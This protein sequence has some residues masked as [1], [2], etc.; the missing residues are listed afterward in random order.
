MKGYLTKIT[1]IFTTAASLQ[2]CAFLFDFSHLDQDKY[3]VPAVCDQDMR[4]ESD[5]DSRL[6]GNLACSRSLMGL[7]RDMGYRSLAKIDGALKLDLVDLDSVERVKLTRE[8]INE[9][10]HD[11]N[12][13]AIELSDL[14]SDEDKY[15]AAYDYL[16]QTA[17]CFALSAKVMERFGND[18]AFEAANDL[19]YAAQ[20]A[21]YG[22][23]YTDEF[24]IVP[25]EID[26]GPGVFYGP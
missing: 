2:G 6:N 7:A 13:R 18:K 17:K 12:Q 14:G 25:E 3:K 11:F 10:C 15:Y 23:N 8:Q 4:V 24:T 22:L 9:S 5:E 16:S 1:A 20:R 19:N 26:L 21:L